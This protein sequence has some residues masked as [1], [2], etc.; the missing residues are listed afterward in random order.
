MKVVKMSRAVCD[1]EHGSGKISLVRIRVLVFKTKPRDSE[2]RKKFSNVC[3]CVCGGHKT[4]RKRIQK[5]SP[6]RISGAYLSG[7][8]ERARVTGIMKT[9]GRQ[10]LD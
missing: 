9:L 6:R 10:I 1:A 2:T 5:D 7:E 8:R 4:G 3:V